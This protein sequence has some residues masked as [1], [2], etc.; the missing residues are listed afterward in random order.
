MGFPRGFMLG[1][2]EIPTMTVYRS[3]MGIVTL[4]LLDG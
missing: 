4:Q 3:G 2:S 1:D